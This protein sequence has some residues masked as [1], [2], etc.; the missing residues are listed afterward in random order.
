MITRPSPDIETAMVLGMASTALPFADTPEEEA[1]R[2]L[3][4]LRMHGEAGAALQAL[5]VSEAPIEDL[6][7]VGDAES[8]VASCVPRDEVIRMVTEQAVR[9]AL[10]RRADV[11]GAGDVLVAVM[12]VYGADFDHVL[13]AHGTDRQEVLYRLALEVPPPPSSI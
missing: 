11:V 3:R 1:E 5:G 9:V 10:A 2:W 13:R 8:S 4:I 7:E 6:S 12:D